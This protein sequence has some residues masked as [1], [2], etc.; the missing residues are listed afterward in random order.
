MSAHAQT[1]ATPAASDEP[2]W[3]CLTVMPIKR[4]CYA[5]DQY[6]REAIWDAQD[7]LGDKFHTHI[8]EVTLMIVQPEAFAGRRITPLLRFLADHRFTP[9]GIEPF[10]YTRHSGREIWRYQWNAATVEKLE[11]VDLRNCAL[12]AAIIVL[13]DAE[14]DPRELPAAVRLKALKGSAILGERQSSCLRSV[15]QSPNRMINFVH[16]ADEPADVVREL[17]ICFDRADRRRILATIATGRQRDVTSD[18]QHQLGQLE[19]A[20]PLAD[21]DPSAAWTRI[22]QRAIG[23]ATRLVVAQR[24]LFEEATRIEWRTLIP[25]CAELG[26]SAW[27]VLTIWTAAVEH[28]DGDHR[29]LIKLDDADL[30]RLWQARDRP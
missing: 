13:R 30:V 11:L 6:F 12:P 18:C 15:L 3:G 9:I 20:A 21:F 24:T 10:T 5:R 23:A 25:L 1:A 7:I 28:K 17:G 26:V 22:Q 16:T 19:A 29:P 14:D 2:D 4:E 27:D 8:D